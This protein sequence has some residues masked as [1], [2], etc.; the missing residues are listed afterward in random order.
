MADQRDGV[1]ANGC[2]E[3]ERAAVEGEVERGQVV[4]ERCLEQ[5]APGCGGAVANAEF[6]ASVGG[7]DGGGADHHV[8]IGEP[9]GDV[10]WIL[11]I[12]RRGAGPEIDSVY[13]HRFEIAKI[14]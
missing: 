8:V 12:E 3:I 13:V 9:S 2:A 14:Q 5:A 6:G 11:C 10:A 4:L 7:G 1:S